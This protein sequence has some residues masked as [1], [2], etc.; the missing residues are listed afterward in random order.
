MDQ[1][2][3]EDLLTKIIQQEID[4]EIIQEAAIA[5]FVGEGWTR[6]VISNTDLEY[7]GSWMQENIRGNWRGFTTQWVFEDPEEAILFRMRWS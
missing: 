6:V 4:R 2:D 1:P 5:Y 7:I 3:I